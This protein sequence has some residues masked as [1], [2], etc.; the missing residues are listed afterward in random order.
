MNLSSF[1]L[2]SEFQ[3]PETCP[4]YGILSK[5]IVGSLGKTRDAEKDEL[6]HKQ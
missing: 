3:V 1:L 2:S 6:G 4:K 5:L